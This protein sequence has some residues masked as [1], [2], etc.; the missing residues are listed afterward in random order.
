MRR[1]IHQV[2]VRRM[3][4]WEYFT[5]IIGADGPEEVPTIDDVPQGQ[6]PKFSVYKLIPYLNYFGSKGWELVSLEPVQVGRNGDIR[7]CG[8]SSGQ[9]TYTYFASFKRRIPS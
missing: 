2:Y 3:D 1:I 9:W 4:T 5:E 8:A 6:H 7:Y